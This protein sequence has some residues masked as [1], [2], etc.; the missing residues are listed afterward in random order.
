MPTDRDSFIGCKS[1]NLRAMAASRGACP[2][3]IDIAPTAYWIKVD[4]PSKLTFVSV[5][6]RQA[7]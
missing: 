3:F 6:H 4:K 5:A 1:S 7:K 2:S